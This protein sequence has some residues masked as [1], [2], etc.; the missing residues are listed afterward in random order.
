VY[1]HHCDGHRLPVVVRAAPL[2]DES[3]AITGAIEVFA[4]RTDR[5]AFLAELEVL[6]N[7]VLKDP[8][9]SLGNRKYLLIMAE[10][11]FK[12]LAAGAAGF[13]LLMVD[14]DL[15][16]RVNDTY[17]HNV[18]DRVLKM[19]A[20]TLASSV[21]PLDAAVRWGGEEF[22]LLCPN[23][24]VEALGDIAERV[25]LVVEH[26]WIDLEPGTTLSVTISIGA[27]RASPGDD[28]TALIA[29][30]D[31]RLYECKRTGRNKSIV[32]D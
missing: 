20:S 1:L 32:G 16:K 29:R 25:R 13:G 5:D 31:E 19:V 30:A 15:F 6:R 24:T 22:I 9:T 27:A 17:G 11:R 8:L 18:G 14:I 3:G 26:C 23:V 4:D 21:R 10:P 2:T 7:E 28:L 12:A